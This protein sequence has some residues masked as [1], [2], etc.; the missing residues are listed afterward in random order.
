MNYEF[1]EDSKR[2]SHIFSDDNRCGFDDRFQPFTL[3]L[4]VDL[5]IC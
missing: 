4:I 1:M 3:T 5:T 2:V